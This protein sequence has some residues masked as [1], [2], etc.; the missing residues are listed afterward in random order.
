MLSILLARP[1]CQALGM[2]VVDL[3]SEWRVANGE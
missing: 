1:S 2:E 3:I